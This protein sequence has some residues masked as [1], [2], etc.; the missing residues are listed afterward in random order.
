M[1]EEPPP[2]APMT[3]AESLVIAFYACIGLFS[4]YFGYRAMNAPPPSPCG[5]AEISPD[6]SPR[7]KE[8]CR[9]IRGHKP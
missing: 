2:R 4:V 5:V 6:V 8:R 3:L 1:S 7:T 9:A